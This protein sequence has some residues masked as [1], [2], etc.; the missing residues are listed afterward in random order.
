MTTDL[1]VTLN[2]GKKNAEELTEANGRLKVDAVRGTFTILGPAPKKRTPATVT[3]S[4][5]APAAKRRSA[6][7]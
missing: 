4:I 6:K 1:K 2:P 5:A 7:P 3:Y